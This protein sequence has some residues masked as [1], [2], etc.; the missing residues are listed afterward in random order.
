MAE[1]AE[2]KKDKLIQKMLDVVEAKK[3]AIAR[4]ERANWITN[5]SFPRTRNGSDRVNIQTVSDIDELNYL[6]AD[7]I[8]KAKDYD[9]A[10]SVL[11]TKGVFK[12]GGFSVDEWS[13][14]FL[15]RV[16]KIN[17]AEMKKELAEDEAALNKIVSPARR[18]ELELERL[19]KKYA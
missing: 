19:A 10:K 14:D 3:V 1:S 6:L 5:C 2:Q 12:W 7:L 16:N 8:G 4:T 9:A 13:A 18:E 17:I 15:T 11:G